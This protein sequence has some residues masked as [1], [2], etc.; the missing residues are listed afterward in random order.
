M[1]KLRLYY[2]PSGKILGVEHRPD[3]MYEDGNVAFQAVKDARWIAVASEEIDVKSID[4]FAV[5][6]GKVV[7]RQ[8]AP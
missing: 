2:D 5:A 7:R 4:A 1:P 6:S 3:E 8:P